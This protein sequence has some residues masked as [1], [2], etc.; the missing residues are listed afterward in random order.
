MIPRP[1][2][3]LSGRVD[4]PKWLE[5]GEQTIVRTRAHASTLIWP[6]VVFVAT[7]IVLGVALAWVARL[8]SHTSAWWIT[9]VQW[10]VPLLAVVIFVFYVLRSYIS[11]LLTKHILTSRRLVVSS[12]LM[13]RSRLEIPLAAIEQLSVRQGL[14]ARMNGY[15]TLRVSVNGGRIISVRRLRQVATMRALIA[16]AQ[17]ELSTLVLRSGLE[18]PYV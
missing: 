17:H 18:L 8:A 7:S 16:Q 10:S 4:M 6:A 12:G 13:V 1:L 11:W 15:G 9:V 5:P 3:S 2:M 14:L